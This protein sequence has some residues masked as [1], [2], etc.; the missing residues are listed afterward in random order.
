MLRIVED[1]AY[2]TCIVPCAI[3]GGGTSIHSSGICAALFSFLECVPASFF[4]TPFPP[5]ACSCSDYQIWRKGGGVSL[6]CNRYLF[7]LPDTK[8][9]LKGEK[10]ESENGRHKAAFPNASCASLRATALPLPPSHLHCSLC[11]CLTNP[12]IHTQGQRRAAEPI[13]PL[14]WAWE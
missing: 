2:T 9:L 1:A 4:R 7:T 3:T 11:L 12:V 13:T 6:L 8:S 5:L 10:R 14:H